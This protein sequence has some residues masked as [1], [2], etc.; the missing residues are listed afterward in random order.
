MPLSPMPK[1][2]LQRRL[3]F[4][5]LLVL[6]LG[7]LSFITIR[8]LSFT[9]LFAIHL[10]GLQ[11]DGVLMRSAREALLDG[12]ESARNQSSLL[13]IGVGALA[14]A[15]LSYWTARRIN[16]SLVSIEKVAYR[17]ATGNLHERVLI[18]PI[19]ELARLGRSLNQMASALEDAENRRRDIVTDLSH[20]LRTPLTVIRGYLEDI[21]SD[22]L[23]ETPDIRQRL[24]TETRRLER[25]VNGLQDLS[26][27]ESGSLHL[28]LKAVSLP[29]LL[30]AL[31]ERFSSQLSEGGPVLELVCPA[32]LA[33]I[34]ADCDRTEQILVNLLGNAIHHTQR[35]HIVLKAWSESNRIWMSVSDTGSGISATELPH[36]FDRFWRSAQARSQHSS[37]TGIGLTIT[38]QLVQLQGGE[39]RVESRVGKGTV[40]SFWLPVAK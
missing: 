12:F 37:G 28:S 31:T 14:S 35:G 34:W 23:Q 19:P 10:D 18:S 9:Y 11:A 16:H 30:N 5:H 32:D 1:F 7:F 21:D 17:F 36:V 15:T 25:L 33:P 4:S 24:I 8:R 20:E 38:R 6:V 2:T 26:K 3:F 40:F 27:A 13:A 22:R 29:P 39:I